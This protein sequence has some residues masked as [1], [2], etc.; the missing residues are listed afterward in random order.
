MIDHTY[1][2]FLIQK[3]NIKALGKAKYSCPKKER[4]KREKGKN[5]YYTFF[6]K[7]HFA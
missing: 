4:E 1:N 5:N 7:G 2:N 3:L 6:I